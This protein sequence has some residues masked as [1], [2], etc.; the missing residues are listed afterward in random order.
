MQATDDKGAPVGKFLAGKGLKLLESCSA[1]THADKEPKKTATL[2]WEPPSDW[3]SKRPVAFRASVVHK[4]DQFYTNI[5][6][7]LGTRR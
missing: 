5:P 1:V 2:V 4:F 7:T 3:K 6:S